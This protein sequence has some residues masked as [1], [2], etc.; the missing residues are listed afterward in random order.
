MG[1]IYIRCVLRRLWSRGRTIGGLA[2]DPIEALIDRELF[3]AK[4]PA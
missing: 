3:D 2:D 4:R 1:L